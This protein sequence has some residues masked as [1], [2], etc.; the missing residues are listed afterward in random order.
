MTEHETKR[1]QAIEV[2][3]A[4]VVVSN[5]EVATG[6]MK[7]EGELCDCKFGADTDTVEIVLKDLY[8]DIAM[9]VQEIQAKYWVN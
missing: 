9:K 8:E 5:K 7:D 3:A 6:I 4:L 2:L 1:K